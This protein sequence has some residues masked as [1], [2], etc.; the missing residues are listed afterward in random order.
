MVGPVYVTSSTLVAYTVPDD[1]T[2]IIRRISLCDVNGTGG[3]TVTTFLNG[4][5]LIQTVRRTDPVPAAGAFEFGEDW[6]LNPGDS[7][8][9]QASV[10]NKVT[11][12]IYG[13]L[14]EGAPT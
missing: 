14:L 6:I 3:F 8:R 7:I 9:M 10:T 5:A 1:R 12:T 11:V 13:S 2:L 4:S